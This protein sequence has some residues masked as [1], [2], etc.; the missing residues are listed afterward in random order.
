MLS[1]STFTPG[2]P[3]IAHAAS[4]RVYFGDQRLNGRERQAAN[5]G[6]AAG[7]EVGVG[8]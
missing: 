2:S 5:G 1:S 3:K 4:G 8:R 6:D 7:L